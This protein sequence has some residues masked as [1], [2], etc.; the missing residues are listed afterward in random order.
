MMRQPGIQRV[1]EMSSQAAVAFVGIG[2][3]NDS[4]A[5]ML[6]GFMT[7]PD[8]DRMIA[9]G[10]VGEITGWAYD[11]DGRVIQGLTNDRVASA[12]IPPRD[13]TLVIGAAFGPEKLPALLG[14]LRG[15]LISGLIT[16]A[17]T[18]ERLMREG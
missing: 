11:R 10:A 5:L 9:A 16:D 17:A 12:P 2:T 18:A 4:A 14:A 15:G 13:T 8:L 6:D 7:R 1:I 3:M